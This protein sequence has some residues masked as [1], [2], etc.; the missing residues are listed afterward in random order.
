M[1]IAR[2]PYLFPNGEVTTFLPCEILTNEDAA[3]TT[4]V[5]DAVGQVLPDIYLAVRIG[6]FVDDLHSLI[7]FLAER[8]SHKLLVGLRRASKKPQNSKTSHRNSRK[9]CPTSQLDAVVM[10]RLYEKRTKTDVA[11]AI[12]NIP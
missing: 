12:N 10:L 11:N 5:V 4:E 3:C 9:Q 7:L 1:S 8:T 6:D 2:L